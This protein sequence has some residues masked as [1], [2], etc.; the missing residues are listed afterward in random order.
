VCILPPYYE[1]V[2]PWVWHGI[3]SFS[4]FFALDMATRRGR[5]LTYPPRPRLPVPSLVPPQTRVRVS[6]PRPL[7]HREKCSKK[8]HS[9]PVFSGKPVSVAK[10]Y[11]IISDN[12]IRVKNLFQWR[13]N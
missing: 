6:R 5:V 8:N 3:H 10:A 9:K 12:N 1:Y 4:E 11:K 13:D 2:P 7:P